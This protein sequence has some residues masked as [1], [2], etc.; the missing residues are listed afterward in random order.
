MPSLRQRARDANAELSVLATAL[1]DERT[2]WTAKAIAGLTVGLAVSP[3]DPIPDFIPVAG[4][5][6]D[7]VFIPVGVWAAHRMIPDEVLADAR[8]AD[9]DPASS[10]FRW[11][12]VALVILL[13]AA[14]GAVAGWL[15]WQWLA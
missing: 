11:L 15:V 7:L 13:W 12:V 8:N 10:R 6:D 5:V 4:Y 3:V 2:P 1:R 9:A 14:G